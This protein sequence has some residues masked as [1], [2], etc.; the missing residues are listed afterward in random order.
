VKVLDIENIIAR[1]TDKVY[2]QIAETQTSSQSSAELAC[3]IEH[4]LLNPDA[5]AD[6]I[7]KGCEE[8][9]QYGFAN[10]CVSPYYVRMAADILSGSGVA[11]CT[12]VGFPH[13]AAS[14]KA[15]CAEIREAIMNGATELD[16]SLMIGAAKSG[17][18]DGLRK[19]LNEMVSV[20]G[21]RAKIKAIYEQGVLTDEEKEKTLGI[22]AQCGVDYIK[23]SNAL[24]GKKACVEDIKY[25]RSVIGD[26]IGIKIDGGIKDAAKVRELMAAG[27]QRFGCSAS[28]QIVTADK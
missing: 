5:S 15:K 2:A 22:A 20:T 18:F 26:K 14:T 19:D 12:V 17:D 6:V 7:R 11:V 25:V 1:I 9:K 24:T 4:S 13:G 28:V 3:T 10:V 23:I 27:A 21:G 8:A 16:V